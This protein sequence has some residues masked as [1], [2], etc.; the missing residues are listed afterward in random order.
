M[1]GQLLTTLGISSRVAASQPLNLIDSTLKSR[2]R[3]LSQLSSLCYDVSNLDIGSSSKDQDQLKL[4]GL[5]Y[6]PDST[7]SHL[8]SCSSFQ[9]SPQDDITI[10]IHSIEPLNHKS[11]NTNSTL[12]G[13]FTT[14][15]LPVT[16]TPSPL[17]LSFQHLSDS[18][19]TFDSSP[20]LCLITSTGDIVLLPLENNSLKVSNQYLKD[21]QE[22]SA[23]NHGKV[24]AA[25]L[26]SVPDGILAASWS[27]D[28]ELLVLVVPDVPERDEGDEEEQQELNQDGELKTILMN[29]D[30][31]VVCENSL[32]VNEFGEGESN[33]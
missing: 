28:L 3:N 22:E 33:L 18:G 16:S 5:A 11:S 17:I 7:S 4:E 23:E 13:Q 29:L 12:L 25:V 26:G 32:Q 20:S 30:F 27:P 9:S 31:D 1:R 19:S 21:Q 6:P 14:S 15:P 2:M 10:Y 24:E 8:Y